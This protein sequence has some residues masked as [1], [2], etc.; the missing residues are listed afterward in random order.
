MSIKQSA[1]CSGATPAATP[2]GQEEITQY[3]D[4]AIATTD[5][6]L[7]DVIQL[8]V[9]PANCVPEGYVLDLTDMDS[10]VGALTL[11]FGLLGTTVNASGQRV[12]DLTVSAAAA[13]GGAKW[14]A[15]ST[16]GQAG[17]IALHTAS[18]TTFRTLK[19]VTPVNYDRVVALVV[20]AAGTAVAGT[21]S[22][23][24][25]YRAAR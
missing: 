3:V 21:A 4:V 8:A 6:D 7:A 25:K 22:L 14:L 16:L 5:L 13:D 15:A 12:N 23:Q 24:L 17:G 1:I 11:D 2:M 9:L 18:A 10:G 19:D 20:S